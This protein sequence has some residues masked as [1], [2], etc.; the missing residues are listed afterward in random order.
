MVY[1]LPVRPYP[2]DSGVGRMGVYGHFRAYLTTRQLRWSYPALTDAQREWEQE[3]A[4]VE[5]DN[6]PRHLAGLGFSLISINRAA[7]AD[8]GQRLRE[9]LTAAG[10]TFVAESWEYL[11]LDLR[12]VGDL[13]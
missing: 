5:P 7:Y 13:K 4:R 11:V 12:P 8:E 10:A 2:L 3:V 6:L 1:Q 9:L